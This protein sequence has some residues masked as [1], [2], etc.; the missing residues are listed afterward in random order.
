MAVLTL[1]P[2]RLA[3]PAFQALARAVPKTQGGPRLS[4]SCPLS[5]DIPRLALPR[6]LPA[7]LDCPLPLF[8]QIVCLPPDSFL[9]ATAASLVPFCP[10]CEKREREKLY[11]VSRCTRSLTL[12]PRVY[13]D[14]PGKSPPT[15]PVLLKPESSATKPSKSSRHPNSTL[16]HPTRKPSLHVPPF[17]RRLSSR[18]FP[19]LIFFDDARKLSRTRFCLAPIV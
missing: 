5:P 15:A 9:P 4:S 17:L 6:H 8:P 14:T 7:F 3:C 13:A 10:P 12:L 19:L 11:N 18:G 2:A 1:G 16:S